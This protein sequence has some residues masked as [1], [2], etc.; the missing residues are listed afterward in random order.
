MAQIGD[1]DVAATT[2]AFH[3]LHDA[4]GIGIL[5]Q[6]YPVISGVNVTDEQVVEIV[7]AC[8]FA[9]G[10]KSETPPTSVAVA[11]LASKLDVPVF[12]GLASSACLMSSPRARQAR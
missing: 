3:R 2:S 7:L 4:T 9:V 6:D 12:G 1:A 11:H 8:P 10:V 5:I